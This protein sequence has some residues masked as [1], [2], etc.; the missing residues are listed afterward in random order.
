[1]SRSTAEALYHDALVWDAH[2]GFEAKP[3]IDLAK[4]SVWADAAVDYLSLN[5][6]YDVQT[7][8]DTIR[9]LASFRRQIATSDRYVLV[10]NAA[11]VRSAKAA[12]RMALSFDIEGMAVLGGSLD[13]LHL[14]YE[15]GV[16][17]LLVA[18]NRNNS[19]GGG[20]HDEDI[21][22]T[23]FGR[24]AI[25]EMN[26]LGMLVDC[27]HCGLQ[28]T[29]D[30]M[31]A[32]TAPVI[33][34]HSNPR[35][36]R[37]HERNILDEQ[38]RACAATGG[39]VGVNGIGTFL[40]EDDIRTSVMADHVEYLMQLIG[41]EH[42]GIGLDYFFESGHGDEFNT[43][44]AANAHYWPTEQ[45]PQGAV[46]CAAPSQLVELTEELLHRGHDRAHVSGVLG[47]NFL[48]VAAAVWG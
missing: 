30:V 16:R 18:Y 2:A 22:L 32:S 34:S 33:F 6:G 41:P 11:G 7:L 9:A 20:C 44:L 42:V 35:A 25:A 3:D 43:V 38:A 36:L 24:A 17:Q 39:V 14:L 37:D 31:A 28:T 15:L 5:V 23:D 19:A 26:T 12:G 10:N 8:D 47:E 13:L 1:M 48:R 45:Y 46:R 21:G 40:G 4:L 29:M 27:S